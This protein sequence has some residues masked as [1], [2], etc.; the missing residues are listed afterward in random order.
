LLPIDAL[1]HVVLVPTICVRGCD[2]CS[3]RVS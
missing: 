1:K 3:R 2:C